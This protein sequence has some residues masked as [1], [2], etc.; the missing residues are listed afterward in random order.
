MPLDDPRFATEARTLPSQ[1][2]A[3]QEAHERDD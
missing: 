1:N 2:Q 3:L